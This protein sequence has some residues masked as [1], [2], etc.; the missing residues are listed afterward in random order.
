[1]P[2]RIRVVA[3]PMPTWSERRAGLTARKDVRSFW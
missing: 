3:P 2:H 1:M